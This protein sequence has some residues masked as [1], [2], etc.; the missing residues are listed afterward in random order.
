MKTLRLIS[1]LLLIAATTSIFS[2]TNP[3]PIIKETK[4]LIGEWEGSLNIQGHNLPLVFKFRIIEDQVKA[5][6]DSPQQQAFDIPVSGIELKVNDLKL[7]VQSIM[8][9][10]S[11]VIVSKNTI[12][13]DWLQGGASYPLNLKKKE[14]K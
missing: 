10:Y 6:L 11:G 4:E 9:V 5:F 13:G 8:G 1:T 14:T 2:Q 12:N 7:T 3:A